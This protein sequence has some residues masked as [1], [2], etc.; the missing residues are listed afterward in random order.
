MLILSLFLMRKLSND[1]IHSK[2][3]KTEKKNREIEFHILQFHQNK[4]RKQE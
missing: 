4:K 1:P 3:K 2:K